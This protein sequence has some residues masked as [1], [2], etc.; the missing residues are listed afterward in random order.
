MHR[1]GA[2]RNHWSSRPLSKD[3]LSVELGDRERKTLALTIEK[4]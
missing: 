3:A 1:R 4:F 2:D